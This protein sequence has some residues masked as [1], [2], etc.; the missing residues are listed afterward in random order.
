[1]SQLLTILHQDKYGQVFLTDKDKNVIVELL[2]QISED[3]RIFVINENTS[4]YGEEE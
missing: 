2:K 3:Y 4:Q 1:V